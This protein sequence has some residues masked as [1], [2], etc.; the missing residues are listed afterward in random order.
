MTDSAPPAAPEPTVDRLMVVAEHLDPQLDM[1]VRAG[2]ALIESLAERGVEVTVHCGFCP[3]WAQPDGARLKQLHVVPWRLH[4]LVGWYRATARTVI[5]A[6]ASG[7]AILSLTPMIRGDLTLLLSGTERGRLLHHADPAGDGILSKLQRA[8]ALYRPAGLSRV[9]LER[10]S[11][12]MS[13]KPEQAASGLAVTSRLAADEISRLALAPD[14]QADVL[15]MAIGRQTRGT[16]ALKAQSIALRKGLGINTQTPII[17]FPAARPLL[18]GFASLM[19]ALKQMRN[20]GSE[21]VVL[22]TGRY[23]YTH[24]SWVAQLGV[25]DAVRFAGPTRRLDVAIAAADAVAHPTYYDPGGIAVLL[26]LAAGKPVV[27]SRA[28]GAAELLDPLNEAPYA[29]VLERGAP[30][31]VLCEALL[32]LIEPESR[33]PAKQALPGLI[34]PLTPQAQA[35]KVLALLSGP[36]L[37]PGV[38]VSGQ[39]G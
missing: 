19:L 17:L 12:S 32:R 24:L 14:M 4:R 21:A 30:P 33:E 29:T 39:S 23:R 37:S 11:L 18:H 16:D 27:T 31:E 20:Q 9:L 6:R 28:C 7:S 26:A 38:A 1:S 2:L 8:F 5:Q 10:R 25:R 15:S 3:N 36:A 13:P 22:L 34:E 35:E